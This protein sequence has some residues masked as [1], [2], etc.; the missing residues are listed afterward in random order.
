MTEPLPTKKKRQ[1]RIVINCAWCKK[2]GI[3]V[4]FCPTKVFT[5][6]EFGAPVISAAEKCVNCGLCVLR[7]PDFAIKLEEG[8][9]PRGP[10][11]DSAGTPTVPA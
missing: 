8:D 2:C 1:V 3:C 9:A 7:C 6:D 4:A 5:A 11:E 10:G